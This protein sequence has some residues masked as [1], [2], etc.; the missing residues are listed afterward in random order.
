MRKDPQVRLPE[1]MVRR[2]AVDRVHSCVLCNDK[3]GRSMNLGSGLWDIKY[4]YAVRATGM[5]WKHAIFISS[6]LSIGLHMIIII[7]HQCHRS[8]S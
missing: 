3:D 7:I 5:L 2:V 4:H 6:L 1:E 8:L